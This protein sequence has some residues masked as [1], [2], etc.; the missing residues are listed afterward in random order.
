MRQLV[1]SS[2]RPGMPHLETHRVRLAFAREAAVC[3]LLFLS[4]AACG[5]DRDG[6]PYSSEL[7][8]DRSYSAAERAADLVAQL[9]LS[10]KALLMNS[11]QSGAVPR[12]SLPAYGWWNEAIHGVAREQTEAG[13]NPAHLINTTSYPVSLSLG[14]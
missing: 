10:E 13:G 6:A 4:A 8:L 11:S 1:G 14:A 3:I 9:T 5:P 7:Y 12:L 2:R